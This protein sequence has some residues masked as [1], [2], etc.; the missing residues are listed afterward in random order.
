[1][2]LRRK[3]HS[4]LN[5]CQPASQHSVIASARVNPALAASRCSPAKAV[6]V[7]GPAFFAFRTAA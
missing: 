7:N 5:P 3:Y 2:P 6:A 1:M 4:A